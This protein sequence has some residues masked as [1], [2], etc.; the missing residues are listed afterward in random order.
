M[1]KPI[2]D[3]DIFV[4]INPTVFGVWKLTTQA[5]LKYWIL[6]EEPKNK[7]SKRRKGWMVAGPERMERWGLFVKRTFPSQIYVSEHAGFASCLDSFDS[8]EKQEDS[9]KTHWYLSLWKFFCFQTYN[10]H[11]IHRISIIIFIAINHIML[12]KKSITNYSF[13]YCLSG[14]NHF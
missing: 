3:I 11:K 9:I 6:K 10:Y 12:Y 14:M 13:Q 1:N 4:S 8:P 7:V 5:A 2:E